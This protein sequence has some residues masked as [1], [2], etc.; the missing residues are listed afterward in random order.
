MEHRPPDLA[1]GRDVI[2]E[3]MGNRMAQRMVE[4]RPA[5]ILGLEPVA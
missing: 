1:Q 5:R 4:T 3:I 2:A